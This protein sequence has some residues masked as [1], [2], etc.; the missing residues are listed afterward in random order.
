[1]HIVAWMRMANMAAT[2]RLV[3]KEMEVSAQ[4]CY[5]SEMRGVLIT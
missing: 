3:M 5:Q 1:M 4:V 2:V